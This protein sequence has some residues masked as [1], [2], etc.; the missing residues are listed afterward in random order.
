M[1]SRAPWRN[2][3][4]SVTLQHPFICSLVNR[5]V[6]M[7]HTS[8]WRRTK[9]TAFSS[10]VG[11]VMSETPCPICRSACCSL[12]WSSAGTR[13]WVER[14]VGCSPTASPRCRRRTMGATRGRMRRSLCQV[15]RAASSAS[16]A[17]APAPWHQLR[18]C[19]HHNKELFSRG[20]ASVVIIQGLI[21]DDIDLLLTAL[22]FTIHVC[23][24]V[25]FTDDMAE[26]H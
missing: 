20:R 7:T 24:I 11:A 13:A 22:Y 21:R 12:R 16:A 10:S 26:Q 14:R 23:V 9:T 4:A 25:L 15:T 19:F 18:P 1:A 5:D 8:T 2:A 6:T 17:S 3:R